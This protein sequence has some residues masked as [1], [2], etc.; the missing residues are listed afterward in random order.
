ML[1]LK[2]LHK[3]ILK[4][5]TSKTYTDGIEYYE[6][7]NPEVSLCLCIHFCKS[8]SNTQENGQSFQ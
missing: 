2:I 5:H 3:I 1:P 6:T 8:A 4:N 7:K